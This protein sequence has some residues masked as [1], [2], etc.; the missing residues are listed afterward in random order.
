[1][2]VALL[3]LAPL[4][5]VWRGGTTAAASRN[6]YAVLAA[7][8]IRMLETRYYNG[9]GEWHMCV[10]VICNTKNRDWGADSLTDTLYFHWQ[11]SHGT[12]VLPFM[13]TLAHTAY[14]Y[15]PADR[16]TSD[17][18][19]WDSVAMAREYQVTG[20][21]IALAKSE[22]AFRWVDSVKAAEYARGACP[23]IDYEYAGG[24]T[25]HLKTLETDSNYIKAALLLYQI[26]HDA[27]YLGKAEAKYDDAREYFLDPAVPL[28]TAFVFD[29]GSSC[30]QLGGRYFASV[31]GNMIWAGTTLAKI[32]GLPGYLSEA[33]AT[34]RAVGRYLSD[35]AGVYADLEADN[36]VVEPLIE[37]MYDLATL[38]HQAFARNWLMTAASAAGADA[39][40]AGAYG[41]FFDGPP[42]RGPVTAWQL[43]GGIALMVAAAALDPLGGP[44][45]PGFWQHAP[46]VADNQRLATVPIRISFTGRAIAII[47]A[48]GDVCCLAGHA[49][50]F[51]DGRETFDRTGI[52]QNKTS[53]ARRLPGEV[54]FAWRWK[55]PGPHTIVISPGI[56]DAME[57]GSFFA[58]TGYYLVN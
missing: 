18:A 12:D 30:R 34:A 32:T 54:L 25:T 31:N 1:M 44:A 28:Y 40:A 42:P 11:L 35:G 20:D 19:M 49:R 58:M 10:P 13:R 57:G 23:T 26:T 9:T 2:A 29:N 56:P 38:D 48:L 6:G 14:T 37:A 45:D 46:F 50:V 21:P 4:V 8:A 24:G 36:D 27:A 47:G 52:W 16:G 53:S 3:V 41:R 22:A 55:V 43:N 7:R 17:V 39:T 5:V 51:I 33:I 15:R